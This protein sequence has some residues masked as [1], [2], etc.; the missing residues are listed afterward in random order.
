MKQK[1][2]GIILLLTSYFHIYAQNKIGGAKD[3]HACISAA[4]YQWSTLT[5]NCIRPFELKIQL[6]NISHT[7]NCGIIF[8]KDQKQAEIFSK[9]GNFLMVSQ[10]KNNNLY[11]SKNGYILEK[12][13]NHWIVKSKNKEIIYQ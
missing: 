11:L 4:G 5:N 10:N 12:N 13:K 3:K 9:E 6:S 1:M 2:I 8:A 7:Y